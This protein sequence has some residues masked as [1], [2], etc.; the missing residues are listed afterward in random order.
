MVRLQLGQGG[1]VISGAAV[2]HNA[3][4]AVLGAAWVARALG[5]ERQ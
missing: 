3:L 1:H 2:L 4:S 5:Y